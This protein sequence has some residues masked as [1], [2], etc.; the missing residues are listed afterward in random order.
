[1]GKKKEEKVEDKKEEDELKDGEVAL[2]N[3]FTFECDIT[4]GRTVSCIDINEVNSELVAVSYGEP[5]INCTDE[6][7][8]K[9]G[10]LC[11]WTLKNPNYPEK[12]IRTDNSITCCEFSIK[13][14]NLIAT[15]DS[16]GVI[17]IFNVQDDSNEPMVQSRDLDGRHTE[18]IW[19]LH[20][21]QRESKGESLISISGDGRIIEWSMKK[22]LELTELK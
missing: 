8:L 5:D 6:R 3:L 2:K 12:I 4:A 20:W 9:Q 13:Q 19:E 7:Q 11:F 10:L 21:V 15:G 17:S 22:G 14:P 1:M 16:H 18:I